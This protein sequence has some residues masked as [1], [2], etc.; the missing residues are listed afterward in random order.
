MIRPR[1]LLLPVLL[2]S[3]FLA[4]CASTPRITPGDAVQQAAQALQTAAEQHVDDYAAPEL[5]IARNKYA[6][7]HKALQ[8]QQSQRAIELAKEAIACTQLASTQAE[9]ARATANR[10]IV[11]R[12]IDKIEKLTH[13]AA[14]SSDTTGA[15]Q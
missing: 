8:K 10:M 14:P 7:A 12:Q 15:D 2:L 1:P 11:Q 3:G 5:K 4:A 9:G 6:A 13:G